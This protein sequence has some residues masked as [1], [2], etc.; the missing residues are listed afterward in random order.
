MRYEKKFSLTRLESFNADLE[1]KLLIRGFVE[2]YPPRDINSIYFDKY[3]F[4]S[5]QFHVSD[6]F[7]RQ[8]I[9]YRWYGP[10]FSESQGCFEVKGKIGDVGWKHIVPLANKV[11]VER[12][13]ATIRALHEELAKAADELK[14][15]SVSRYYRPV[16]ATRYHRKYYVKCGGSA[17]VT[18]DSR[19]EY[20]L[21]TDHISDNF[22]RETE[23]DVVVELKYSPQDENEMYHLF[24][25]TGVQV[26][27]NSKY[28]TA[29]E[30]F[31]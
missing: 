25:R 15:I 17:R 1:C 20:L 19:I 22:C 18:L 31:F 7:R 6:S 9:R 10:F 5:Y 4:E 30:R 27:K 16:L 26:T 3:N 24:D 8:K 28:I 21:C 13:D 14:L 11:A 12:G 29:I 2:A 23:V